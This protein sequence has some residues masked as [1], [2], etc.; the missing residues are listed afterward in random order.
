MQHISGLVVRISRRRGSTNAAAAAAAAAE[1][2]QTQRIESAA[3]EAIWHT[4]SAGGATNEAA[5]RSV[6]AE[7]Q[8]TL[9]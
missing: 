2:S 5:E 8:V 1:D 4:A 9:K 3:R 6:G 7:A